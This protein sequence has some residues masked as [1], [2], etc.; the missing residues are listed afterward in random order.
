MLQSQ[1]VRHDWVTEKQQQQKKK[2]VSILTK[3][4]EEIA[5][6]IHEENEVLSSA[7]KDETLEKISAIM[8]GEVKNDSG[9]NPF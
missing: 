2:V 3:V 1:R 4:S 7:Q 9:G 6:V 5:V 8:G